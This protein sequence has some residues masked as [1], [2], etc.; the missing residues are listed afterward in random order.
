MRFLLLL[1]FLLLSGACTDRENSPIRQGL[2]PPDSG[3]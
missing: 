1:I 3:G 2:H